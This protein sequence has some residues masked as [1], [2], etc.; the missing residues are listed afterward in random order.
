MNGASGGRPDAWDEYRVAVIV[1]NFR[2]PAL[3]EACVE[4]LLRSRGV[5]PRIIVVDNHSRDDSVAR[6]SQLAATTGSVYVLARDRNDGYTGGNNAGLAMARQMQAR[7]AF[8]LNSDTIVDP[9][10]L[11]RL[12]EEMQQIGRAHV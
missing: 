4:S 1:V 11:R 8:I 7:Y 6:L 9:D 12:V 5:F 10:C 3:T 2:T